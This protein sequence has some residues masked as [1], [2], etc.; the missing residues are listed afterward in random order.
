MITTTTA[1]KTAPIPLIRA[2]ASAS[3]TRL[4]RA[5][6]TRLRKRNGNENAD[7]VQAVQGIDPSLN[8]MIRMIAAAESSSTPLSK[9]AGFR[10][11]QLS[12]HIT[13]LS[14][15]RYQHREPG[16][17]AVLA[18]ITRYDAYVIK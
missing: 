11:A 9:L 5:K 12:C 17:H 2:Y 1:V 10:H 6:Q 14:H 4:T 18:A 16:I 8:A 15:N 7:R 13:I 3:G